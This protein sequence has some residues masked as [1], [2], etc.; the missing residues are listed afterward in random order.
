MSEN[1][2]V[3]LFESKAE[4]RLRRLKAKVRRADLAT[5]EGAYDAGAALDEIGLEVIDFDEVFAGRGLD[6]Y[7]RVLGSLG[8]DEEGAERLMRVARMFPRAVAVHHSADKLDAAARYYFVV[9]IPDHFGD[10][11][12]GRA[13]FRGRGRLIR[14]VE[15]EAATAEQ[16][17]AA[18]AFAEEPAGRPIPEALRERARLV[19]K[20]VP[21]A[22]VAV[23]RAMDG[24]IC[25]NLF[26]VPVD[27]LEDLAAAL[28]KHLRATADGELRFM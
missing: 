13:R 12:P 8:L 21:G 3:P 23:Q 18:I 14:E 6:A 27:R 20:A 25:V 5:G 24:V 7:R 2:V 22:R 19:E 9:G 26:D 10:E 28:R 15:I 4:R 16:L 1:E 11:L 17:N